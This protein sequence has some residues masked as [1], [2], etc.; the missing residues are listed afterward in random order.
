M[1]ADADFVKWLSEKLRNLNVDE[2]VFGSYITG[3][4]EGDETSE[5]KVE[6]LEGILGAMIEDDLNNVVQEII[7]KW[8]AC[9]PKKEEVSAKKVGEDVDAQLAR[10][11]ES[12]KIQT[13][14]P[15]QYT[16]EEMRIREQILA[17]YSQTSV[18]DGEEGDEPSDEEAQL[19]LVKNTN[20]HDVQQAQKERREQAKL[21]SQKKKEK[22]KEDRERQKQQREEK[23]EKRKTVKGERRR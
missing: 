11:L 2:S 5:E 12:Q 1:S 20:V 13:T 14:A 9:Q 18:S 19:G 17:Q 7:G 23:K 4:L 3:I 16:A 6:A 22:D 21:D 8:D 10:M 15:R